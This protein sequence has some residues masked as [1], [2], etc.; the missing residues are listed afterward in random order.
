MDGNGRQLDGEVRVRGYT[1]ARARWS[2]TTRQ[3]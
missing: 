3:G 2:H 1:L